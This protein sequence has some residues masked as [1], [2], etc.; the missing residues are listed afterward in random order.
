MSRLIIL[1]G[2]M[3]SGKSEIGE[4]LRGKLADSA[5]LDLDVNANSEVLSLDDVLGKQ[6]VICELYDGG[7]HTTDPIWVNKFREK[8][9]GMLSVILEASLETCLY[10]VLKIRK[11]AYSQDDVKWHY[12]HFH[13]PQEIGDEILRYT[14]KS[15]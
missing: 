1:R 12:D 5:K 2:P 10:R 3:G 15:A 7:S 6:N 4:Y 14:A 8:G 11:D 9:Y 13:Q